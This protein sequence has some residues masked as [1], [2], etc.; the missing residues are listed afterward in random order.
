MWFSRLKWFSFLGIGFLTHILAITLFCF[1][2][3]PTSIFRG[4][5]IITGFIVGWSIFTLIITAMLS[6]DFNI[7]LAAPV[8]IFRRR[9]WV[10][11]N[12]LGWFLIFISPKS[13]DVVKV[14][15]F[16]F[17]EKT[18]IQN[19]GK[20]KEMAKT[21]KVRLDDVYRNHLVEIAEKD[22]EKMRMDS[23][24]EWDGLLIDDDERRDLR[25]DN[26]LKNKNS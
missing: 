23:L 26:I 3:P 11:H 25:I 6:K 13:I 2:F 15:L 14:H 19:T 1:L 8:Y 18:S 20:I 22:D 24:K 10:Y 16:Y 4:I 21:M 17:S 12:K 7:F 5:F 9:K